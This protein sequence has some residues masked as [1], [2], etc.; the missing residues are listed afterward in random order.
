VLTHVGAYRDAALL[1]GAATSPSR[2]AGRF[3]VA[4]A[5]LLEAASR[6]RLELGGE[7]AERLA[8]AGADLDE[9]EIVSV[10]VDA[11]REVTR[12]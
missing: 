4:E 10:A 3:P 12:N 7:E 6:L 11:V 2:S 1:C 8:A 5:A 9:A